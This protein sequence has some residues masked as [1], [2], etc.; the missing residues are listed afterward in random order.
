MRSIQLLLTSFLISLFSTIIARPALEKLDISEYPMIRL[1]V[2]ED[3][4]KPIQTENMQI[5]E[6]RQK[7]N[8]TVTKIK[9]IRSTKLRRIHLILAIHASSYQS[10]NK[11]TRKLA[12]QLIRSLHPSD[13]IGLQIYSNETIF[14]DLNLN[15]QE[16]LDRIKEL[17]PGYGNRQNFNL[18]SLIE[19]MEKPSRPTAFVV[20]NRGMPTILDAT[21]STFIEKFQTLKIPVYIMGQESPNNQ[22]LADVSGGNFFPIRQQTSDSELKSELYSFRK[23]PP[24]LTFQ[25]A[26]AGSLNR[27]IPEDLAIQFQIGEKNYNLKYRAS[28]LNVLK[29]RFARVEIF[30]AIAFSLLMICLLILFILNRTIHRDL[31][32]MRRKQKEEVL[33]NDL[34]YQE[35]LRE[36][37]SGDRNRVKKQITIPVY[38]KISKDSA[39]ERTAVSTAIL[40]RNK[41]SFPSANDAD[42]NNRFETGV[43]IQKKGP[44]PG[45]QFII[46]QPEIKIGSKP[47]CELVLWDDF[48]SPIHA[49]IKKVDDK[50]VLFDMNSTSG[51]YLNGK[52]LLRPKQL[53]DFDEVKLGKTILI[54]RGK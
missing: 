51:V 32:K 20:I 46:N 16:A 33:K 25:T 2:R 30:F 39:S 47:E 17:S 34:Y 43:L 4:N 28:Y 10:K 52:K 53:T 31:E 48:I 40:P 21:D 42:T 37:Q 12:E 36:V 5:N 8:R 19:G 3:K 14:Q 29:T 49:R 38:E 45:R 27:I 11:K 9:I 44:N 7:I 18:K 35:N 6:I 13:K 22:N 26:F 1:H 41:P 54:F 15:K 23:T 24:I 50:F